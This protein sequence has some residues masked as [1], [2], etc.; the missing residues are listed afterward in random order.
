M[1]MHHGCIGRAGLW[2]AFVILLY[3]VLWFHV[4]IIII[5]AVFVLE[6]LEY[7]HVSAIFMKISLISYQV[8]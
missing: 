1:D 5:S 3:S 4:L 8:C 2:F 6:G 7:E